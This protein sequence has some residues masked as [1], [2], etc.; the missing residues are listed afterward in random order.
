M[1]HS[2]SFLLGLLIFSGCQSV[3]P[4]QTQP[5]RSLA[6]HGHRGSRGTHP[7]NTMSAFNEALEAQADWIEL[8]LVLSKDNFPIVSHDPVVSTDLCLDSRKRPIN[9][10]IPIKTLTLNQLKQFDCGSVPN[11][12]FPEQKT[13]ANPSLPTLEE[14]L[15]WADKHSGKG[16]KLNIELKMKSPKKVWEP[17]PKLFVD[18][19]IKLLRKYNR[20]EKSVLQSFDPRVLKEAK[21]QEPRLKLSALF[22]KPEAFCQS[23]KDQGVAIAS[24]EFSLLTLELVRECHALGI[25]VH[26]WTLNSEAEWKRAK[27][28]GVDGIITDYPRKLRQY[29]NSVNPS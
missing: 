28:M 2:L 1:I 26:P 16:V 17:K 15:V 24:P 20:I 6:I 5:S 22:E 29:L 13:V 19:V 3:S 8:D 18:S 7:E 12:K 10:A 27:E 4:P 11:P 14:V 21:L 25:E 9:R 23:A